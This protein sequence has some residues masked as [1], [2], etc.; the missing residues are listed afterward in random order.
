[1]PFHQEATACFRADMVY[2]G[3]DEAALGS[4]LGPFCCCLTH[5]EYSGS[6][7][8]YEMLSGVISQ[9]RDGSGRLQITDSK[10]IF[11]QSVGIE[12]LETGVL[13]FLS[14]IG[15]PIPS[16]FFQLL[17]SLCPTTD[18]RTLTESPWF[19]DCSNLTIPV[20]KSA[21]HKFDSA[22]SEVMKNCSVTVRRPKL[23]FISAREFNRELE[24]HG[25]KSSA[26]QGII[27]PLLINVLEDNKVNTHITVDRQGGRRY[28]GTW[29]HNIFPGRKPAILS[30]EP[31]CSSYRIGNVSIDFLV[32]S[33]TSKLETALASM[34]SKYVRELAM[35]SFNMWW[36]KRIPGIRPCAGYPLDAKRFL[37][38]LGKAEAIDEW[39]PTLVRRR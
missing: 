35:L 4:K 20:S 2:V 30:E 12:K 11:S 19:A 26:V 22:I 25:D 16:S 8:L 27:A 29:L 36:E 24:S 18:L 21:Y 1:L 34:I 6:R 9:T 32:R 37:Q 17:Q 14:A 5:F 3:V 28:Y 15:I 38:E 39:N 10:A 31:G 23:R 13:A 7:G 33:E